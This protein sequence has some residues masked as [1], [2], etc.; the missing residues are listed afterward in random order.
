MEA[1][2][3]MRNLP[4]VVFIIPML[5]ACSTLPSTVNEADA[6]DRIESDLTIRA[7]RQ[8][9][10][11]SERDLLYYVLVGELAGR[12]D[13]MRMAAEYYTKAA[14]L[15][16][17]P[18]VAQRATK[19]A[20]F[21]KASE[22]A[23]SAVERWIALQPEE[24]E[25]RLI[26][27]QL[28][29]SVGR[30][31]DAVPHLQVIIDAANDRRIY[32]L[33]AN[34]LGQ[35]ENT[36]EML[37]AFQML[38]TQNADDPYAYLV[39]ASF[40]LEHDEYDL[41]L[42]TVADGLQLDPAMTEFKVLRAQALLGQGDKEAA[43]AEM[44]P[45]VMSADVDDDLRLAYA[46]MLVRAGLYDTAQ[47]I[48]EQLLQSRPDDTN[49]LRQLGLLALETEQFDGAQRIFVDHVD[50]EA[51]QD[52]AHYFLGRIAET[53]SQ[54]AQALARYLAVP[55][56]AYYVEARIRAA[57]MAFAQGRFTEGQT[58]LADLRQNAASDQARLEIFLVE[59][60]LLSDRDRPEQA[61]ALYDQ[62][63]ADFPGNF[64]A[65]YAR[66]LVAAQLGRYDWLER[67]LREILAQDPQHVLA[68]NALGYTL[69][70]QTDRH[71]EALSYIERAY[72][73]QPDDPAIIDSMGWVHYRLGDLG[74][75]ERYLRR[76]VELGDDTEIISHLIEVLWARGAVDE[77]RAILEEH[78]QV[79]PK[80]AHLLRVQQRLR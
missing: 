48:I 54:H 70:D 63:L 26:V 13:Q 53:R 62:V 12:M 71:E 4:V 49:L 77:A 18:R 42:E 37:Q 78:L 23:L 67:D 51:T 27:S 57:D 59:G 14:L 66:A 41:A 24:I 20:V 61:M 17:D 9:E 74:A 11:A 75:A 8:L 21:V 6:S 15:S 30:P 80:D 10:N 60:Q 19:V 31:L 29:V 2:I 46:Q 56:G 7:N 22:L 65:L 58:L 16:D 32:G 68:L 50:D 45:L 35:G 64:D 47:P 3:A 44:R 25:P 73:A 69:A 52:M 40:A 1:L 39:L 34:Q 79:A 76:A 5:V 55:V 38:V 43:L 33:I 72:R 28:L 36:G